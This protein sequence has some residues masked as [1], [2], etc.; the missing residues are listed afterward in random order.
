MSVEPDWDSDKCKLVVIGDSADRSADIIRAFLAL[1]RE[2]YAVDLQGYRVLT[3]RLLEN[4]YMGVVEEVDTVNSEHT[5]A[6]HSVRDEISLWRI[7]DKVVVEKLIQ[8]TEW[9]SLGVTIC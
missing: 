2:G 3:D 5:I 7:K 8:A 6:G 1:R 9:E 4:D